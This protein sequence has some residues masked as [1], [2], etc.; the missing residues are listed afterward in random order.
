VCDASLSPPLIQVEALDA[1]GAPVPG[2]EV[3][4]VWDEGQDHFF[5]GLKPEF[6]KELALP[7]FERKLLESDLQPMMDVA[8]QYKLIERKF[9]P[10]E[11]IAP[12]A[13]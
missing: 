12:L 10:K 3:L 7:A 13:L 11:V 8:F 1:Q 5:T 4:I 6:L 2:A 9:P